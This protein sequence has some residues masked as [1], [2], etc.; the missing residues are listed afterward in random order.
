MEEKGA[1]TAPREIAGPSLFSI[2]YFTVI[3]SAIPPPA[4]RQGLDQLDLKGYLDT[5]Q[6]AYRVI[7]MRVRRE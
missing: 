3:F 7:L 5:M 2:I 4:A 6:K 1:M